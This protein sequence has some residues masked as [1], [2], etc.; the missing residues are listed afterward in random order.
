[1]KPL[2]AITGRR[3]S[4]TGLVGLDP[5]WASGR[6]D[7]YWSEFG[8]K[9]SAAGGLAVQLPYESVGDEIVERIDALI[10]TGGQDVDPQ[11]WG[12]PPSEYE[13]DGEVLAIDR[14]RDDYEIALVR[15]ALDRGIPI[16]GVCRGHQ[17]LN[18][19]L[20]GT[21]IPD[22]PDTGV[23]HASLASMPD[24]RPE[25]EHPVDFEPGSLAAR[26]Y[27]ERAAVNSWHHQAV[28]ELGTGLVASGRAPDG[29]VESIELPGRDVLGLQ[30]HPEAILDV[31]PCFEWV[32]D[33][34]RTL[35][36]GGL[37]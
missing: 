19:A 14:R 21:L 32:V 25:L 15:A 16:L 37:S 31:D 26:L 18:V 10:V 17:V 3:I 24:V 35:P 36:V 1:M 34:A 33:R 9:V 6:A 23:T 28:A 5:R 8:V 27:G 20:G 7:M 30:W 4:G 2:V 29:V 11:V 13:T 12:G 22:L